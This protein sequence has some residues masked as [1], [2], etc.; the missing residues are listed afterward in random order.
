M[1]GIGM[2]NS[3]LCTKPD[4][5]SNVGRPFCCA[6]SAECKCSQ[7]HSIANC[8]ACCNVPFS[9]SH[10]ASTTLS[11]VYNKQSKQLLRPPKSKRKNS[12]ERNLHHI[13]SANKNDCISTSFQ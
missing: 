2:Q 7:E 13:Y 1:N 3:L 11:T 9:M 12:T 8:R 5:P 10:S 4:A 6:I